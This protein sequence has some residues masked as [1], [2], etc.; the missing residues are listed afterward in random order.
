MHVK[1][2]EGLLHLLCHDLL[3]SERE[4]VHLCDGVLD[5]EI[6]D[7]VYDGVGVDQARGMPDQRLEIG[8]VH[9]S[10]VVEFLA[11]LKLINQNKF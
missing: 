7:K 4:R 10:Y 5:D 11:I 6:D 9:S 2:R 3:M 1:F 8:K